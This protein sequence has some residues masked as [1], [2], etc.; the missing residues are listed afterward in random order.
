MVF[1]NKKSG[2]EL[3]IGDGCEKIS[4]LEKQHFF[5]FAQQELRIY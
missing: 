1:G 5:N 4:I 2:S 3:V